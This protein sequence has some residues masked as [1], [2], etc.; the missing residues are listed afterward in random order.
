MVL[1]IR[2]HGGKTKRENE[3]DRMTDTF[4][5]KKK[6]PVEEGKGNIG[7]KA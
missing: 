4:T 7:A 2:Y 5:W 3:R 1:L 6:G